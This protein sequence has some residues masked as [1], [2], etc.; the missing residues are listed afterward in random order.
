MSRKLTQK[1]KKFVKLFT[2][3]NNKETFGNGTQ[4]VLQTYNVSS[5]KSAGVIASN[6]LNNVSVIEAVNRK[7]LKKEQ[8]QEMQGSLVEKLNEAVNKSGLTVENVPLINQL[9]INIERNAKLNGDL[10]EKMQVLNVNVTA[11]YSDIFKKAM[12]DT[13]E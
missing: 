11:E 4:S 12:S 6:L 9:G 13:S 3:E 10:V 5:D 2:D 8:L 7:I 1:R